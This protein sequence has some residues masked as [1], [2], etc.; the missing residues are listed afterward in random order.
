[1]AVS[2][3]QLGMAYGNTRTKCRKLEK[4]NEELQSKLEWAEYL[5]GNAEL[6]IKELER[7]VEEDKQLWLE[8]DNR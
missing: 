1:M 5:L 7:Q 6:R 8:L 3:K 2:Y 4:Q